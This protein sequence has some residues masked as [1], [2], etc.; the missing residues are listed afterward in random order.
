[1]RG[2]KKTPLVDNRTGFLEYKPGDDRLLRGVHT[3]IGAK[4]FHF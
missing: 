4:W 2:V 3:I 1:M